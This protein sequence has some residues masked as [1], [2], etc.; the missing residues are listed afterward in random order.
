MTT[1]SRLL[2]AIPLSLL[3]CLVLVGLTV[4]AEDGP[5]TLRGVITIVGQES[6]RDGEVVVS[7]AG[8][9]DEAGNAAFDSDDPEYSLDLGPGD[10]TAYAWAPVFR[11]SDRVPFSITSNETTWVNLTV[12]RIEEVMGTVSDPDGKPIEGA[13]VDIYQK[14]GNKTAAPVTDRQ[15]RF[16]DSISPGTYYINVSKRGFEFNVTEVTIEPGQV[17]NLTIE[18][19]PVPEDEVEEEFPVLALTILLFIIIAVVMSLGYTSQQARRLRAAKA[20][21]EAKRARELACPMCGGLVPEGEKVCP[22]CG[23]VLQLRCS[24]CGSPMD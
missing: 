5:G 7:F 15:G 11:A 10:Y 12:V 21:A 16:R 6:L 23:H 18:M 20:E 3:L 17:L 2:V 19:E 4:A 1:P 14:D 24:E 22:D 9:N 13:V 8:T